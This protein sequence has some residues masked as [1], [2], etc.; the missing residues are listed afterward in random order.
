MAALTRRRF[1]SWPGSVKPG[2]LASL[3]GLALLTAC[4]TAPAPP[5]PIQQAPALQGTQSLDLQ[6]VSF[7][8]LPGWGNDDLAP[9][10]AALKRSCGRILK[11]PID[12]AVGGNGL[13]GLVGDWQA[14][15]G[16]LNRVD[17]SDPL[18]ALNFIELWFQPFLA[19][20]NGR[21][22]G[23]FTGYY[24]AE[25]RGSRR[26]GGRFIHPLYG[27]PRDLVGSGGKVG[28]MVDGRLMPY[29]ERREIEA[30]A[31]KNLAPEILWIDDPIDIFFLQIQGSGLVKL[32]D[33]SIVR[34][35]FAG[36]NGHSFVGIGKLMMDRKIVPRDQMSMQSIRSW[37]RANPAQGKALMLENPRYIFFRLIEGDGPIG[38]LGVPLTAQRS[39]AVDP[40]FVPLG[41]PVWL[42]SVDPDNVPLRRLMVAQDTGGAIKG[43]VRGDFFWGSGEDALAKAGR[44]KSAGR[45]YLLLPRYRTN[46]LAMHPSL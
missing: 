35:G 37:L 33:G 26:K 1:S 16:A 40:S 11:Q 30:G 43:A 2:L 23:L 20:R 44:M 3:A 7:T 27:K 34:V 6:P 36:H 8:D 42:D 29:P 39:L 24:E 41:I 13:A 21:A 17:P 32:E 10:L 14:P 22:D 15:C 38:A 5:P 19:S 25:L 12:R 9:A 18:A 28:R 4:S 46:R 31:L 45:Y